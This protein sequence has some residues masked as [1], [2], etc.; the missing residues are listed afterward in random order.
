MYLWNNKST[1]KN[2]GTNLGFS[3][4]YFLKMKLLKEKTQKQENSTVII[5][6]KLLKTNKKN[7]EKLFKGQKVQGR[8]SEL[9]KIY[10][11]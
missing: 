4:F 2:Q 3:I 9:F 7:K 8:S 1:F 10:S 6:E 5:K 11:I